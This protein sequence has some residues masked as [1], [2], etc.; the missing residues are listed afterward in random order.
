MS[1]VNTYN[2]IGEGP[3]EAVDFDG[4]LMDQPSSFDPKTVGLPIWRM[5]NRVRDML[6]SGKKVCI[7]SASVTPGSKK[8]S[9]KRVK[10]INEFCIR[11]FGRELP[12]ANV[13]SSNMVRIWDNK[14]IHVQKN[15]GC[16]A[17]GDSAF[18]SVLLGSPSSPFTD[19]GGRVKISQVA[20]QYREAETPDKYRCGN[21]CMYDP[22]PLFTRGTCEGVLGIVHADDVCNIWEEINP[23]TKP[24]GEVDTL[25]VEIVI[26]EHPAKTYSTYHG[27]AVAIEN[28]KG[29]YRSG[30]DR[31][32][33]RW[34]TQLTSDYGRI[35]ETKK[36]K[37][38]EG[39]DGDQIDVFLGPLPETESPNIFVINQVTQDDP[40]EFDEHKVIMGVSSIDEARDM[41]LSN[42]AKEWVCGSIVQ[43]TKKEFEN[44]LNT[45]D[46]SKPATHSPS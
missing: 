42:Y 6:S 7:F 30:T 27:Y 34:R 41:Y 12:I 35:L 39:A 1:K 29:S 15:T 4:T 46:L 37:S 21:C 17:L 40:S 24:L 5:V 2:V 25:A 19:E 8:E 38:S 14:A 9:K 36:G 32:G 3:I 16:I 45:V 20:A 11:Y 13:K 31:N 18:Y 44:W 26:D 33:T 28:P 10:L 22:G 43:F 23:Y